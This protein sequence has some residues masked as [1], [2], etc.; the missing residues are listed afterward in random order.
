MVDGETLLGFAGAIPQYGMTAWELHPLVV[1][2]KF[3]SQGIGTRLCL[4]LNR[5]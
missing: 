2:E 3:R 1:N 5:D 4:R